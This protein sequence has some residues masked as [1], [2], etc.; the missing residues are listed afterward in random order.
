MPPTITEVSLSRSE[1]S[2]TPK[3][4]RIDIQ[5]LR[6]VAVASVL[7]FHMGV[8]FLPGGFAG[9]DVFFVISGFL[10][11]GLI[12]REVQSTGS[13]AFLRFY[14]RRLKRLAPVYLLV[15]MVAGIAVMTMLSP[16]QAG[17]YVKDLLAALLYA[18]NFSFAHQSTGYFADPQPSPFVHF[19]SLAVEEQF[20]F[21]WPIMILLA[22]RRGA[23]HAKLL[24]PLL[25]CVF[26]VS[27]SLSVVLSHTQPTGAYYLLHTR[28]W[29]LAAGA[30]AYLYSTKITG[31]SSQHR[32]F[33]QIAGLA[34]IMLSMLL[35]TKSLEFPGWVALLPVLGTV[36][37]ILASSGGSAA[38]TTGFL[39]GSRPMLF[40]GKVSYS[41]YLWHWP[42]LVIP[43]LLA[44]E[45]LGF[46]ARVALAITALILSAATYHYIERPFQI[47]DVDRRKRRTYIA[48][49]TTTAL[50]VTAFGGWGVVQ[51][52]SLRAA[53]SSGKLVIGADLATTGLE[54][55]S[56]S[57]VDSSGRWISQPQLTPP[58][59]SV[60]HDL[61]LI[62]TN[63]CNNA[64]IEYDVSGCEFGQLDSKRT[65]VL[66]GDSHAAHWFP[67]LYKAAQVDGFRLI[68]ITKS[69]CPS[70]QLPISGHPD[71][72]VTYNC[73][74]FQRAGLERIHE[75]KPDRI[76]ISNAEGAYR[77]FP[78]IGPD[79]E[80]QWKDGLETLLSD[81]P[82]E[83]KPII[84]GDNPTWK[85]SPNSC[86]SK[87]LSDSD[88][89]SVSR[90]NSH[91]AVL[92]ALER[93]AVIAKGGSFL[94]TVSLLCSETACPAAYGSIL[95]SRDGNHVTTTVARALAG[96]IALTIR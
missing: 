57:L 95:M 51:R 86:I 54:S 38:P 64:G 22:M 87:H 43:Q 31:V 46:S 81:L 56:D 49:L 89:C 47:L 19:W 68:T 92:Q 53:Q 44:E 25:G 59:V 67:A 90:A 27:L 32:S 71:T 45:P 84:I 11:S 4:L 75:L 73:A 94:D 40:L 28:A 8:P 16:L 21:L 24:L 15:L 2:A 9:V 30:L 39:L 79:Y 70:V 6:A 20:Y 37:V 50:F 66:F 7:L 5:G 82:A 58:I 62:F 1:T 96:Q 12:I 29:E 69:A 18:A 10:I 91:S 60:E 42:L 80:K 3:P 55:F 77:H 74:E 78:G 88:T 72:A 41:L 83:T 61:A 26:A 13:F 35:I 85:D 17:R 14:A 36:A 93:E 48:V 76:V 52:E 34:A 33:I 23:T 63:G 65:V